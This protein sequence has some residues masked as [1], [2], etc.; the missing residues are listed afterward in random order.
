MGK[1]VNISISA[2]ASSPERQVDQI[3]QIAE[4]VTDNGMAARLD[5]DP[6]PHVSVSCHVCPGERPMRSD[7]QDPAPP[8]R[9]QTTGTL[10]PSRVSLWMIARRARLRSDIGCVRVCSTKSTSSRAG[11]V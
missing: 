7:M 8:N 11:R 10:R 6:V 3:A 9:Y 2:G 5:V 1:D 4:I